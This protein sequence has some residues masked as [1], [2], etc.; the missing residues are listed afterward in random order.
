MAYEPVALHWIVVVLAAERSWPAQRV[1][2]KLPAQAKISGLRVWRIS[3]SFGTSSSSSIPG[4]D[5]GIRFRGFMNRDQH[6]G[7]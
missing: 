2:A 7:R 6:F 1:S 5:D 4:V 3:G